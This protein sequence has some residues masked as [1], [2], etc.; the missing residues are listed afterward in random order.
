MK[1]STDHETVTKR[2]EINNM[3]SKAGL[4]SGDVSKY[5]L[6]EMFDKYQRESTPPTIDSDLDQTFHTYHNFYNLADLKRALKKTFYIEALNVIDGIID[7]ICIYHGILSW[8]ESDKLGNIEI[9]ESN[10]QTISYAKVIASETYGCGT[11]FLNEWIDLKCNKKIFKYIF[12]VTEMGQ[13][14]RCW[15]WDAFRELEIGFASAKFV[16]KVSKIDSNTVIPQK[17]GNDRNHASISWYS[18]GSRSRFYHFG[19]IVKKSCFFTDAIAW[20]EFKTSK[21]FKLYDKDCFFMLEI[22][23]IDNHFTIVCGA[24][25]ETVSK[26]DIP[27]ELINQINEMETFRIGVSLYASNP[28]NFAVGLVKI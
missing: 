9:N 6:L 22:N 15:V 3:Y 24:M 13:C 16:P 27:N 4:Q 23:L 18:D 7:I 2:T 11:I 26:C 25:K 17:L 19:M 8:S 21:G 28:A 1:P 20:H 14:T 12:K 10:D 5:A